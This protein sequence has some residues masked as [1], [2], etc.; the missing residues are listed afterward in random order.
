MGKVLTPIDVH[1][2]ENMGFVFLSMLLICDFDFF[3]TKC[4]TRALMFSNVVGGGMDFLNATNT[5]HKTILHESHHHHG[6]VHLLERVP[7]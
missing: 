2:I 7:L 6:I 3:L 5:L 4:M 1:C